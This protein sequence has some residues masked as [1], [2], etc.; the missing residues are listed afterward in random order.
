PERT[1]IGPT[2]FNMNTETTKNNAENNGVPA[3][4]IGRCEL[5][6]QDAVEALGLTMHLDE[7]RLVL[8]ALSGVIGSGRSKSRDKVA[9][10]VRGVIACCRAESMGDGMPVKAAHPE[11]SEFGWPAGQTAMRRVGIDHRQLEAYWLLARRRSSD[12]CL[13]LAWVLEFVPAQLWPAV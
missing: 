1:K 8:A 10:M 13:P 7:A 6:N 5:P 3:P 9:Q 12:A 4:T 11:L 2:P